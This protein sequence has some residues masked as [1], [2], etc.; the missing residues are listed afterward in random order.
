MTNY[1]KHQKKATYEP[2]S[3][4]QYNCPQ[5]TYCDER[6]ISYS[7][8]FS[9][10]QRKATSKKYQNISATV[11]SRLTAIYGRI[12]VN[13]SSQLNKRQLQ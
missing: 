9:Q 1:L 13:L 7:D 4:N 8:K 12:L 2:I 5:Y 3:Q 11:Q 6:E 10:H